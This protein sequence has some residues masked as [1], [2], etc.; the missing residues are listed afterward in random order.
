MGG[1]VGMIESREHE[2]DE[3]LCLTDNIQELNRFLKSVG[4]ADFE[5]KIYIL[6]LCKGPKKAN[7]LVRI[8]NSNKAKVYYFLKR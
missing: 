2:F 5:A 7:N 1:S 4:L 6:L 8:L 3:N